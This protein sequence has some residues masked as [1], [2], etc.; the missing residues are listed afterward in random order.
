MKDIS[1]QELL[2]A[3]CHFGHKAER[4]HPKASE[5]IYTEKDG[6]HV[7]DLAQ[8]KSRLDE[9]AVF[10]RDFVAEGKELLFVGTKRQAKTTVKTHASAV[11][12]PFLIQRWIGGFL[13]NW[14]SISQNIK[15]INKLAEEETTGAWKKFPKHEQAKLSRY[16][17]R[18]GVL[19][20]GVLT[21]DSMPDA[22]FVVD[23]RKEEAAVKE[24]QRRGIPV[25]AIVDTNSNPIDIDYPIPANDDAVGSITCLVEVIT[26]AYE[27]GKTLRDKRVADEAAKAKAEEEKMKKEQE[28]KKKADEKKKED[29]KDS[30]K[31]KKAS[32]KVVK[33][34]DEKKPKKAVKKTAAKAVKKEGA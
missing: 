10:V 14:D 30:I 5:F 2:E 15:K 24:A 33:K 11:G 6:I 19:Y 1:L 25:V 4:W 18:L 7:I 20:E 16:L 28:A 8:T 9:A 3:G 26:S 23:I 31:A 29:A 32:T 27:E 17:K 34:D 21:L 13:T 12:A 22:V